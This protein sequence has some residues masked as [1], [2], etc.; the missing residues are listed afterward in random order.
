MPPVD[1]GLHHDGMGSLLRTKLAP[2][3]AR[4]VLLE[5]HRFTGKEAKEDGIVDVLAKPKDVLA[6]AVGLAEKWQSKAR[7]G[8]YGV[9][10]DELCGEA[11]RIYS[12]NSYV[13][14]QETSREPKVKL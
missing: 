3:V 6:E 10:R 2:A 12:Q 7:M 4:K 8:V 5:A 9:L 1:L 14:R 13:H 11:R